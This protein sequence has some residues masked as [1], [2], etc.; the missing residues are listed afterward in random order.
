MLLALT[1][2]PWLLYFWLRS[3]SASVEPC[4][5]TLADVAKTQRIA[6]ALSM[7]KRPGNSDNIAHQ[8]ADNPQLHK[9]LKTSSQIHSARVR[10]DNHQ[11][12]ESFPICFV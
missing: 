6:E 10:S 8:V 11:N 3:C 12:L 4:P 2:V 9:S 1:G 7:A 5:R